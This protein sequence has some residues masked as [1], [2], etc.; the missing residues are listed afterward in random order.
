MTL[1]GTHSALKLGES[2][3]RVQGIDANTIGFSPLDPRQNT[4]NIQTLTSNR[5]TNARRSFIKCSGAI[6][7]RLRLADNLPVGG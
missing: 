1:C 2:Y 3:Q 6:L 5:K 7:D 4:D